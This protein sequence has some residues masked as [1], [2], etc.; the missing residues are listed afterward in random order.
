M[1]D[2]QISSLDIYVGKVQSTHQFKSFKVVLS[3]SEH[4]M[5]TCYYHGNRI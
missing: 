2:Q 4:S 3:S 5:A 1:S